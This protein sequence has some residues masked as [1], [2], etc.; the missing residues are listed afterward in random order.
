MAIIYKSFQSSFPDKT[1]RKLFYPQVVLAGNVSTKQL[2]AEVAAYSSLTPGDVKNTLDNLVVVMA[3]HL[4]ASES[5]T[6]DGL[7]TFRMAMQSAGNG[8][9]TEAEVSHTQATPRVRF[10][11]AMTRNSDGSSTRA[12][13]DG[14]K[15]VRFAAGKVASGKPGTGDGG[16]TGGGSDG[17]SYM[18]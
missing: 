16:D 11:P 3:A 10:L 4:Q 9:A 2:A 18:G 13:V 5:V 17:P 12:L 14:A 8:V 6:L 7:G 1:G 15:F